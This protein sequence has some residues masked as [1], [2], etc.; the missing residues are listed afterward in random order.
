MPY[1][2][3][4]KGANFILALIKEYNGRKNGYQHLLFTIM[5][6]QVNT[7]ILMLAFL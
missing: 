5:G 2:S 3:V 4:D 1:F 6:I 7:T